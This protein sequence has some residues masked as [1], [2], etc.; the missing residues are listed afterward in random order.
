MYAHRREKVWARESE[1]RNHEEKH[2][3][4][5]AEE[6][7]VEGP[8]QETARR[9][10]CKSQKT[11]RAKGRGEQGAIVCT[12]RSQ[13]SEERSPPL[14]QRED[15]SIAFKMENKRQEVQKEE[16][17]KME[18]IISQLPRGAFCTLYEKV[19]VKNCAYKERQK[20]GQR[21]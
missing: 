7:V 12:S 16:D 13:N 8:C 4:R 20:R 1:T 3:K 9:E 21:K 15:S 5:G 14:K 2:P 6:N 19:K 10:Q 17:R 18:E 11:G